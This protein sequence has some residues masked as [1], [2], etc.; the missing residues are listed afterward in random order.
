MRCEEAQGLLSD[1]LNGAL[2]PAEADAL[3]AHLAGCPDCRAVLAELRWV[4]GLLQGVPPLAPPADLGSRIHSA[5]AA[6]GDETEQTSAPRIPC[7]EAQDYFSGHLEADLD[8]WEARALSGHLEA[9]ADCRLALQ[10][11]EAVKALLRAVPPEALPKGFETRIH[12]A[13]MALDGDLPATLGCDDV[14]ERLSDRLEGEL[15]GPELAAVDTHLEACA[16]CRLQAQQLEAVKVLLRAVPRE[17]LPAGLAPRLHGAL[18]ALPAEGALTSPLIAPVPLKRRLNWPSAAV[19]A[20]AAAAMVFFWHIQPTNLPRIETAA[21][22]TNTNV[23][24]NI[25]FD[26]A[27]RVEG[28]TYQIDLPEGLQFVDDHGKPMLAQSVAWKGSLEEGKTVVPI[29]VRG[30]R[31]GKYEIQAYVRKGAMRQ[32]TT[33]VLPVTG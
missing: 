14:R 2:A 21:V 32:K 18:E 26:V 11:L 6:L 4:A 9:C 23:A 27:S 28:V 17:I 29:I 16:E 12:A 22:S 1:H 15:A 20:V 25:G 30:M 7:D 8:A 10:Q 31:P 5:L 19:G 3:E 24:V 13:L 33:I